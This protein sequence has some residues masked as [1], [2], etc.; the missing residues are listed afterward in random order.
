MSQIEKGTLSFLKDLQ[1]NNNKPWFTENKPRYQ[2][3]HQNIK[4]FLASLSTEMDKIDQIEKAKLFRIYRDVRFSKDKTPYK[5]HFS[6]SFAREKPYL[7][8]G[9]YLQ[10]GPKETFLATGFWNPEPKDL[11]LIRANIDLAP[12]DFKKAI[13]A[14]SVKKVYGSIQGDAVK[15]SPKGYSKDHPEIEYIRMKQFIFTKTYT[16]K[17]TLDPGFYKQAAKDFKAIRPF[18]D[19]M[20]DILTHNLNGEPLY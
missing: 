19:Y 18:F 1:E 4:D 5:G 12:K 11:V 2:E 20:S 6:L 8:G 14:S 9:Y 16:K 7:R 3:A 17:E 10:V 13:S 15:T